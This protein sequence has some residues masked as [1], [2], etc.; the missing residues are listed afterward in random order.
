MRWPVVVP[1]LGHPMSST[2]TDGIRVTTRAAERRA[3]VLEVDLPAERVQRSVDESVRHLARRTKVPGFRP[4]KAPRPLLERALGMRRDDPLAPNPVYDDA[5]DH[6]F[7]SSVIQA[8]EQEE[9]D[10]LSIPEP[11]WTSFEEGTGASYRV[12]L[13]LRPHVEL[14]AYTDYPFS[15]EV[16]EIN[17]ERVDK[18]IEQLR[19]QQASL[20]PVE[21]RGAEKGDYAVIGFVGRREGEK[22]EGAEAERLPLVIGNENMIPGFEDQLVGMR[23]DERKTFALTFPDDYPQE[24]L[25]G[26]PVEF[27]VE[28]REL[29]QKRL[30]DADDEF[31]QALGAYA[32]LA[33]LREEIGRRLERSALDRA[34][35]GFADR[36]IEFAVANAT[37]ELPDLLVEREVEVMLD[38]L[39]VR[40]AEQGIGLDDY[41][42]ATERDIETMSRDLRPDAEKRVKTLLVLS[43]IAERENVEIPD[44]ELEAELARSRERYAGNQSLLG[45]LN[46]PRGR[47]YTRSLLRRA[48][49]V[50]SLIDRW[51][52]EHP[53]F[54]HVQHLHEDHSGHSHSSDQGGGSAAPVRN[55]KQRRRKGNR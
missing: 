6:L 17:D 14:G 42:R 15:I 54:S 12:T 24:E 40:V 52:Q 46:S 53:E 2:P 43:E 47:A 21:E 22:I 27:E 30:P 5:K 16:E 4:G 33:A 25:A 41:L 48:Q 29:R 51:I 45:Y 8:V 7:E 23:E 32:D 18:V 20:V 13:T 31:A 36:I 35:H 49:T 39:R 10:V 26:Q 11:E 37:V 19:D 38:E 3:V 44:E 1:I 9:L 28:L 55:Q 50:E 34:R